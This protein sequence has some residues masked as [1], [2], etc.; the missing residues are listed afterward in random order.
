MYHDRSKRCC[1]WMLVF[2]LCLRLCLTAGLDTK[3]VA[4]LAQAASEPDTARFLLF[5]ETGQ[6]PAVVPEEPETQMAVVRVL[7]PQDKPEPEPVPIVVT[8]AEPLLPDALAA[9]SAISLAGQCTYRVDKAALLAQP[10]AL[11][12]VEDGPTVLIVHTH[13]SEAYTPTAGWEYEATTAYRTLNKARS[14]IAVGDALA[15][16]LEAQGIGVIHDR[17]INDHP[18]YNNSYWTTLDRI[19]AL[20]AQYPTIQMVLDIH[21][22]A[23]EDEGGN[24]VA[25]SSTQEGQSA[26]R[27]ML[28]VGT[29]QGG[30]SHPGWQ[31]N[32]ANA[33]KL[34][35]VLEGQWP[36][37]CRPI[38]LRTERFNQ[39]VT[40]GSLLIE[41]GAH[42]NTL[43][44]ALYSAKLLGRAVAA[45][46][47]ALEANNGV[48]TGET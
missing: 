48:L 9:A 35:S 14:V 3:A 8:Q 44:Q 19:E 31:E 27:L 20:L 38:D 16:E 45:M 15:A 5:L 28:V 32:L 17:S 37:L 12:P 18:T 40:P 29:D 33:L 39:H 47:H 22:D 11:R 6:A 24:A 23:A 4:M 30:L 7:A 46:L 13:G 10:S 26:A 36:G 41:V 43:E 34:Q 1:A 2:S 42:G 25:L 21:R